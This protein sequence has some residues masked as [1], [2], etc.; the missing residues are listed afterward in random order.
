MEM[1]SV[2]PA[3]LEVLPVPLGQHERSE[4]QVSAPHFYLLQNRL[5]INILFKDLI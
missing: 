3:L 2:P 1:V 4:G 5:F